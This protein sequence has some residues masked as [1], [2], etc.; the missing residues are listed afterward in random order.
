MKFVSNQFNVHSFYSFLKYSLHFHTKNSLL[1]FECSMNIVHSCW[2]LFL[3]K[4][5]VIQDY[6]S[7]NKILNDIK[8]SPIKQTRQKCIHLNASHTHSLIHPITSSAVQYTF[9]D[10]FVFFFST[11][12]VIIFWNNYEISAISITFNINS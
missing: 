7:N 8:Y 4:W 1:P 11:E 2:N 5:K 12:H 9:L 3:A 10:W 6:N